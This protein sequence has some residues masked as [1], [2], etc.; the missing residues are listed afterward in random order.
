MKILEITDIRVKKIITENS[1]ESKMKAVVSVTLCF[2]LV[3]KM[4]LLGAAIAS[5]AS[6]VV[7]KTY[8]I[9]VGIKLYNTG[10]AEWKSVLLCIVGVIASVTSMFFSDFR[11]DLITAVII[12]ITL[13]TVVNKDIILLSKS[14]FALVK[15]DNK[16]NLKKGL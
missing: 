15:P 5:L 13:A 6:L 10:T 14:I 4:G 1:V 2:I 12:I 7:S 3:P 8:R 16:N 9:L 11:S